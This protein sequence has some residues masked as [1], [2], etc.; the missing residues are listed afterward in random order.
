MSISRRLCPGFGLDA[1]R[2]LALPS[3][4]PLSPSPISSSH[5][6][7]PPPSP[8][9]LVRYKSRNS[10]TSTP[11]HLAAH[12]LICSWPH[13]RGRDKQLNPDSL[14]P[15]YIG[16][17]ARSL[18]PP[19]ILAYLPSA[20]RAYESPPLIF[21]TSVPPPSLLRYAWCL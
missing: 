11:C 7:P 18:S 9:R 3:A 1:F 12:A 8:P 4:P 21:Y 17:S 14:R 20:P 10:T 2:L 6:L 15:R 13:N 19:P 5:S 16:G